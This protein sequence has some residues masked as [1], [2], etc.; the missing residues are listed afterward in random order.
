MAEKKKHI[1]D[2]FREGLSG[3]K[4]KPPPEVWDRVSNHL[5]AKKR[6]RIIPFVMKLAAGLAILLGLGGSL[7]HFFMQDTPEDNYLSPENVVII[8]VPENGIIHSPDQSLLSVPHADLTAAVNGAVA[9]IA[10]PAYMAK[11]QAIRK[12]AREDHIH[13]YSLH[14]AGEKFPAYISS[15][16]PS[17]LANDIP[18]GIVPSNLSQSYMSIHERH[19]GSLAVSFPEHKKRWHAGVMMAPNYSY[20]TLSAASSGNME[21]AIYTRDERGLLSYT[22]RLVLSYIINDRL[23]VQSGLDFVNTGQSTGGVRVFHSQPYR[24][25]LRS[26]YI[27]ANL[28]ENQP[29]FNNSL[30]QI[31]TTGSNVVISGKSHNI[32]DNS[33]FRQSVSG[34]I[35]NIYDEERIVQQLFFIQTPIVLRYHLLTGNTGLTVSGGLGANV[36]AGNRVLLER[37]GEAVN[38]GETIGISNFNIAGILGVGL[39]KHLGNSMI[40][41]FEPRFSHF[42]NSVN[43]SLDHRHLPYSLS[44]YGGVFYRF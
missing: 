22:G 14:E 26:G 20:R 3:H 32:P 5:T 4:A 13:E 25:M 16:K 31:H 11:K 37:H 19:E 12:A 23:S 1:D 29:S 35:T 43:P 44:V 42:L 7:L 30:G 15:L 28:P 41:A 21:E 33:S 18:A 17:S 9:G 36:L 34:E 27:Q 6:A 10:S 38:I 8:P 40:L 39:E 2:L 24:E